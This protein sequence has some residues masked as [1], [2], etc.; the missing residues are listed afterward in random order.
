MLFSLLLMLTVPVSGTVVN[1]LNGRGIEG[2]VVSDGYHCTVT[3]AA[4]RYALDADSLARTI[5]ITVPAA[6]EIPFSAE[7][8]PAF[9][10]Y[11]ESADT[12]F[13]LVPRKKASDKFTLIAF[14]DAHFGNE[15]GVERFTGES[16][17]DIQN[18]IDQHSGSGQVIGIALGDQVSDKFDLIPQVK[19]LY[20]GFRTSGKTMPM[21]F[22]ISAV[23]VSATPFRKMARLIPL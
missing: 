13:S 23:L 14:T 6:Y 17:P 4:G 1:S 9:Y 2:V 10:K 12:D 19:R 5:S 21:F 20:S 8:F 22:C 11:I 16:I 7:G 3:D 15:N 18:T